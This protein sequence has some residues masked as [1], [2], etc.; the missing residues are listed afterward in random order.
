[1]NLH[2][3]L[4]PA[5]VVLGVIVAAPAHADDQTYLDYLGDN[6][7]ATGLMNDGTKVGLGHILCDQIRG[8]M[9]PELAAQQP[10][11]GVDGHGVVDAAQHELCPD[12]LH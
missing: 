4:V 5:A 10:R 3:A 11:G 1:M 12:T 6:H 8:G 2:A 9:S 7:I